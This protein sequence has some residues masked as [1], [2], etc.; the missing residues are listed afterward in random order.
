V[1]G[2]VAP[3]ATVTFSAP[4]DPERAGFEILARDTTEARWKH[5]ADAPAPGAYPV[6]LTIDDAFFAVRSV[7][8]NGIRS[9]AVDARPLIRKK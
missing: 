6:A 3:A 5:L 7:G 9:I 8:K 4:D 1:E 2:A